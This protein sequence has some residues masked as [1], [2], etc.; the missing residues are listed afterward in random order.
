VSPLA[1]ASVVL[2][3]VFA[4]AGVL[5]GHLGLAQIRRTGQPGRGRALIGVV[6]SY[7]VIAIAVVAVTVFTVGGSRSSTPV[8]TPSVA[9][10]APPARPSTTSPPTPRVAPGD[11]AGLLP[12]AEQMK[13]LTGDSDLVA[14]LTITQLT[15]LPGGGTVDR[16]ECVGTFSLGDARVYD[17]AATRGIYIT[18]YVATHADDVT[19]EPAQGVSAYVDAPAAQ[20]ALENVL[21]GWRNCA[22]STF[23]LTYKGQTMMQ[24]VGEP[25][26][27]GNGVTTITVTSEGGFLITDRA[28]AAKA[29]IVVDVMLSSTKTAHSQQAVAIANAILDKIPG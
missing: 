6:L 24:N 5:L 26:D 27:A 17:A 20:A 22:G 12:T 29:N 11:L 13:A 25:A 7:A 19:F 10:G 4:P 2:A 23:N 15:V 28:A 3:F 16:P 21:A 8:S 14:H 1:T 9:A 18:D